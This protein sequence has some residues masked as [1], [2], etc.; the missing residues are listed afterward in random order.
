MVRKWQFDISLI[1]NITFWWNCS[2]MIVLEYWFGSFIWTENKAQFFRKRNSHKSLIF[3]LTRES[4]KKK[5]SNFEKLKFLNVKTLVSWK[6]NS[7]TQRCSNDIHITHSYYFLQSFL[8]CHL[9]SAFQSIQR[10]ALDHKW[11]AFTHENYWTTNDSSQRCLCGHSIL[12]HD[13]KYR[14]GP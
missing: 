14:Q 1:V 3:S 12:L 13:D 8:C 9:S 10:E 2:I 11:C 7:C 4:G 5:L 6:D